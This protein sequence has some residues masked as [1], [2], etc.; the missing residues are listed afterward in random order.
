MIEQA[1]AGLD[2]ADLVL[3]PATDD[4]FVLIGVRAAAPALFEDVEW[5]TDN[6]CARVVEN[7]R[8]LGWRVRLLDAWTDVDDFD[9]LEALR[10]RIE[11]TGRAPATQA[12]LNAIALTG[13]STARQIA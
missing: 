13:A 4:G 3:G 5:S 7:A 8:A 11:G 10:Q 9:S 1:F 2:A 12:V 6:V